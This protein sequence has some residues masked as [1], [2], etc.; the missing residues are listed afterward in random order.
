MAYTV[1]E[2]TNMAS[3]KYA[4]RIFDCVA[5]TDIENGTFGYLNGQNADYVGH[6]VY[7]FAAGTKNGL[8]AGEIVVADN[9]EWK[10]DESKITNQRRDA[11]V[12][13]AG[14]VFR[15]RVVRM[16]DEF[17]VSELGFTAATKATV[18]GTTNFIT[19]NVYVTIDSSTGKL[20]ATTTAPTSGALI[21]RIMR[22]RQ[23]G[24]TIVTTARTYGSASA[25]YEIKVIGVAVPAA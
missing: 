9:P 1:F 7:N 13:P 11:Y 21:G 22:K 8:K 4:E 16:N 12:I 20:A 18:T 2:S 23:V 19:S 15:A 5:A 24:A 6:V 25:L 14:T 17:A 3:T 10:E